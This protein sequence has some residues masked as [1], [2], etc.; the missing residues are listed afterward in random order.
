MLL[1]LNNV[2]YLV[3]KTNNFGLY[4]RFNYLFN[5]YSLLILSIILSNI[6][7]FLIIKHIYL[8]FKICKFII[9]F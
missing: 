1:I 3:S 8:N 9:N 4:L 6:L 2:F 5:N 7:L